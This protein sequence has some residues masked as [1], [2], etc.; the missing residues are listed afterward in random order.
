ML[1]KSENPGGSLNLTFGV[2]GRI[3]TG[4]VIASIRNSA[5]IILVGGKEMVLDAEN[6]TPKA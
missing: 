5:H 1:E 2:G 3:G 6:K 4:E